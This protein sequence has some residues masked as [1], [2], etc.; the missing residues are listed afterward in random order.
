MC[1]QYHALLMTTLRGHDIDFRVILI[2]YDVHNSDYKCKGTSLGFLKT[3]LHLRSKTQQMPGQA[4]SLSHARR[5][6]EQ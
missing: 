1:Y 2:P 5:E 6:Q 3:I 4:K